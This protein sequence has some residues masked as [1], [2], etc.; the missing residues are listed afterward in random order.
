M[1]NFSSFI[2][3]ASYLRSKIG[4]FTVHQN[5]Y[6][7]NRTDFY[8]GPQIMNSKMEYT[9]C[10]IPKLETKMGNIQPDEDNEI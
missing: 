8:A 5:T 3:C 4:L 7:T 9:R 1:L 2:K 10:G 6:F